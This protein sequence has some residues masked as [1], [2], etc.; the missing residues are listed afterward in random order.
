MPSDPVIVQF[1]TFH[2]FKPITDRR[3]SGLRKLNCELN[4]NLEGPRENELEEGR[5]SAE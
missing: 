5:V 3:A 1:N 4:E 2:R